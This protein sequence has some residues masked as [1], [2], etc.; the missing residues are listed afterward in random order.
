MVRLGGRACIDFCVVFTGEDGVSITRVS[1]LDWT[2]AESPGTRAKLC[3][4]NG[5]WVRSLKPWS[6][7][8]G[9]CWPGKS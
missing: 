8:V 2:T 3:P 5:L 6:L 1:A 7:A 9:G 4:R